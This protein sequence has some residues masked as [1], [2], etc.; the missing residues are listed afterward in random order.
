MLDV[1]WSALAQAVSPTSLL[2][3]AIGVVIG[4]VVGVLPGL[5]G[6]VTLALL[7]PVTFGMDPVPAFSLLLGM[8]VVS[9]VA[10]DFTS[11]LFGIPGEPTA[12][13]MVLDGYPLNKKGQAGRALGAVL[14][15]SG[16]GAIFGA[17]VLML[18]I[19]VVRPLVL[20]ISAPELFAVGLL[21]LTFIA[22]LSTGSVHKGL[23]MATL[24]VL[25]AL[26]G[27]DPNLG[28]QRYTFGQMH[29]W[30]GISIVPVVVG[31]LGGAEV[32]QTMLD[33]EDRTRTVGKPQLG[34]IWSG[35]K[36]TFR[37]WFLVLR[38]SAIG[39]GLGM[40]PGLGGSV[41]Q[42][43]AYGHAKQTSKHPEE[44][45]DGSIEGVIAAGATTTAKDGGHLVPTI[46]FGI[47]GS[48]SMAVLLGAFLIL[49]L[50]P[51]PEMLNENLDITVSLVWIIVLST[52]GAV[53]L[54]YLMLR[55]LTHLTK[56]PGRML[57][58]FLV[59][60]LT[61]GAFS[62]SNT[63][64]DVWIMLAFLVIGVL[65]TRFKWPRIPLLL[66]LVLGGIL[67]RYFMLSYN[68]FA[69]DW[70]GRPGVV[71]VGLV[72]AALIL[73]TAVRIA[74]AKRKAR[75][76]RDTSTIGAGR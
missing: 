74:W 38:T 53:G 1:I 22:S 8:Y 41:S 55:P 44:F 17:L 32:L 42:F 31:L 7:I 19:P 5:G 69:F 67:E 39:A 62:A 49:G 2:M 37:H 10:G 25:I 52:I 16:I 26:V 27:M 4:F 14:A 21:G 70:V 48:A 64:E 6:A 66:G 33:K 36:E 15:S 30:E 47:P 65:S 54:G 35:A 18:L 50:N 58:P 51:G 12:A 45:G 56:V 72:I 13:A 9:S 59:V 23:V 29:L 46:A 24:G 63:L 28:V 76:A 61:V 57:V 3:L 75:G 34:G 73:T 68:M 71:I 20:G 43:V 11:V 40:L 60:L